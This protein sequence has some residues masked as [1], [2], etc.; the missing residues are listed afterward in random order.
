MQEI[1]RLRRYRY[2][3]ARYRRDA[4]LISRRTWWQWFLFIPVDY[5]LVTVFMIEADKWTEQAD[6]L[7][8]KICSANIVFP[9]FGRSPPAS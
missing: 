4:E 1:E 5:R 2:L 6:T 3:A 9:T 8:A 7:Q